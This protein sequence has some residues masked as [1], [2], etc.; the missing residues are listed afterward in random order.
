M[1]SPRGQTVPQT[2]ESLQE[3]M[4]ADAVVLEA[5]DKEITRLTVRNTKLERTIA[6]LKSRG[7]EDMQFEIKEQR[8][9]I[10]DHQHHN[11]CLIE[12]IA[13][14]KKRLTAATM[15]VYTWGNY[16]TPEQAILAV[17][18]QTNKEGA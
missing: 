13:G 6:R 12:E 8:K 9:V 10:A 2:V 4:A 16:D 1:K 5:A 18:K 11:G 3:L 17:D 14:L 15:L 7:I